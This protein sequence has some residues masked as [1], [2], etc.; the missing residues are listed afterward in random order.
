M[1]Q[2]YIRV[3]KEA[4]ESYSFAVGDQLGND[5]NPMEN[6]YHSILTVKKVAHRKNRKLSEKKINHRL[7]IYFRPRKNETI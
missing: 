1:E 6:S 2:K 7:Y 5:N 4:E 3:A